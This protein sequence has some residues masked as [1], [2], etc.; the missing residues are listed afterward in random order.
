MKT[1]CFPKF[2]IPD[3]PPKPITARAYHHWLI[4][5]RLR[6]MKNGWLKSSCPGDKL[7]MSSKKRF[8]I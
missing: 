4:E 8:Q 2:N 1:I 5:N 7:L 6:L 3:V